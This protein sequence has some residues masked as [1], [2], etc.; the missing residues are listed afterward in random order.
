METYI[1]DDTGNELLTDDLKL[2]YERWMRD[3]GSQLTPPPKNEEA[4]AFVE[5]IMRETAELENNMYAAPQSIFNRTITV[6]DVQKVIDKSKNNKAPG[7]DSIT[8][9]G[10]KK[11]DF[12]RGSDH[13][14][15]QVPIKWYNTQ[16]MDE[17]YY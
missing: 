2:V 12:S 15:Q 7:L 5:Q 1:V 13:S 10:L 8:Y 6:D 16:R 11:Q 9:E 3:F 14:V 4:W 17:G